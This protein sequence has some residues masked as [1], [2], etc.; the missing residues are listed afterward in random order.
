MVGSYNSW[1][2]GL[3]V[4]L[5]VGASFVSLS[6]ASH[7]HAVSNR[8]ANYWLLGGGTSMG[9][10]IWATHF[11][12]MLA[13]HLPIPVAYDIPLT[14]WSVL[15][16][17][18]A[19]TSA[20]LTVRKTSERGKTLFLSTF[21]MGS[22]IAGMHYTGMAALKMSPAIDYTP[23]LFILSLAFAYIA[24]YF[25]LRLSFLVSQEK[26][27]FFSR[28][29]L[30]ASLV[31]G[32]GIGLMHYTAMFA[33]NFVDGSF[34]GA[35][36]S[37][38]G[39]GLIS[40][41]VVLGVIIILLCTFAILVFDI[42][43]GEKQNQLIDALQR[44][45]KELKQ[46]SEALAEKMTAKLRASEE[47]FALTTSGSGD[48][49]WDFDRA[50]NFFWYSSRFR[51]LLGFEDENDYPNRLESWSEGLHEADHEATMTA[52]TAHLEKG[53]PLDVEC[54]LLTKEGRWR[55]F[56]VRGK[57]L[58]DKQGKAYR[59]AGSITDITEKKQTI[60]ALE[61]ER[62]RLQMILDSSP[63]G[64]T[65]TIDSVLHF[66]NPI[67]TQFL[68]LKV[69]DSTA[70]IYVD[71]QERIRLINRLQN[72]EKIKNH[73]VQI[74]G[75]KGEI[76]EILL[77]L[78]T[79]EFQQGRGV[80][81]WVIDITDRKRMEEELQRHNLL[82][83]IALE[84]T[85][86]AYW[87]VDYKDP[88][89]YYQS[90]RAANMLGEP[91]REHGRYHLM[92]EWFS[93]LVE[94]D[95]QASE[96]TAERYQGAIDG[97]YPSYDAVYAYKRPLDG[98]IIWLH[99]AGKIV[100]D[101]AGEILFMYGAYQD[102]TEQKK[103]AEALALALE[104]AA[105]GSQA[106]SDFLANMSHEIRTPMNAIIGMSHLA[107]GTKLNNRQRNY[108]EK[109]NRSAEALL[110]ILNDILDFSKIEAGKLDMEKVDFRLEDV[111][112]SLANL[113]GLKAEEKG[114]E[115]L[116]NTEADLPMA[117]VGDPLRLG[118]IL[119]NLGNNA[120][121]FTEKGEIILATQIKERGEGTAL[122]HFSIQDTG[123]GMTDEQQARLFQSF[124]QAD[125]STTR[126]YGGTGLGLTI[127]KRLTELMEGEV[128]VES[129]VGVG[130]I[131][132]FTARLGI[133]KKPIPR[134]I[135]EREVVNGLKILVVDDNASAREILAT[136]ALN[137]GMEVDVVND[138]L[139]GLQEIATAVK[140]GVPYDI[141]LMDW[142]MPGMDGVECM[143]QLQE[144][145]HEVP[146]AVIMVTAYGREEAMQEAM[147]KEVTVKS[148]LAK[149]VTPSS[150]L[151]A[152]GEVLERGVVREGESPLS[153]KQKDEVVD[154]LAGAHVLLVEDNE[155]NQ[156]LA[157]ELL[158]NG[159]LTATLAENGQEALE[160]LN[161]QG[162]FDGILMDVQMPVMD[163]YTACREIRKQE[164][165]QHLPVIAMTA[166]VMSGDLEKAAAAGMNDHIGKPI[167]V[168]EMFATM[169]KWITP[170]NPADPEKPSELSHATAQEEPPLPPL[171]GIDTE[172][173]L[174]R[175][176][177][178][179]RSYVKLLNKF[180]SNQAGV[181]DKI[182]LALENRDRELAERLAHT[183][184][185][186][187]GSVGAVALQTVSESVEKAII[188]GDDALALS[189]L[190]TLSEH[191]EEVRGSLA[192]LAQGHSV[193][194][195]HVT[196]VSVDIVLLKPLFDQL[197]ELLKEDDVEAVN[198]VESLCEQ[199]AGSGL[200][201]SLKAIERAIGGYDFDEAL[202]QFESVY[203][204]TF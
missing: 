51:A 79:I 7:V 142:Q 26:A 200:E 135:V 167:N 71:P 54:R 86:S 58:R 61:Q 55:W 170:A 45:N 6:L 156:E 203:N 130:S 189:L 106:K 145:L 159:G 164:K 92:D 120:I 76:R 96:E 10:G 8:L 117:L 87:H 148:V 69:G 112:D 190:P 157:L 122:F 191:L 101:K 84:L 23:S 109:V 158:H 94:A 204:K 171:P 52:F 99:A 81:S 172:V 62:T 59:T 147:Q 133:Q 151:D 195:T 63:V 192:T 88:E 50:E 14:L 20:L 5:A 128:W 82:S 2:V 197:Y 188:D 30:Y 141:V 103:S 1:L 193:A 162:G 176:G 138:G 34:C 194:P 13:F 113:L 137:F 169:A 21:L 129:K 44:S 175:V 80:L 24:S 35:L 127:S 68:G 150:L 178:N 108:I 160:I 111:L 95:K 168:Q 198:V 11:V 184:K 22:G 70:G 12:G 201:K 43:L 33:A 3:S 182:N 123:I 85:N 118:Q 4:V 39:S 163:G 77:T 73:E 154:K 149:P 196:P 37:G 90:E 183:L 18:I 97:T 83:N 146:P 15:F 9:L 119:V 185:G 31:M 114:V 155:I 93:R 78:D 174:A 28:L 121:K 187:A 74:Y 110:G 42:K 134:M 36:D 75:S 140:K 91:I 153:H 125:S 25:A 38:I 143:K 136:M 100:R 131:F 181:P 166:N 57:S 49:L 40:L 124:S 116:F 41:F 56:K 27:L 72:H 46:R 173:G 102:I 105:A 177:G 65:I 180:R 202:E 67:I 126:K 16:A 199:L 165:F 186:V 89:Y 48:G 161:G 144:T 32:V 17:V 115:L 29:R 47:R 64:V 152:V 179:S 53:T 132:H 104:R 60:Q 107:L 19:S 98:E 66:C 139:A